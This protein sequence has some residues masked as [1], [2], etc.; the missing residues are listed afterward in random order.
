MSIRS[1]NLSQIDQISILKFQIR[2]S[3]VMI[4]FRHVLRKA[5]LSVI[6][7]SKSDFFKLNTTCGGVVLNLTG[8]E[9]TSC[10]SHHYH[11]AT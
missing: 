3:L 11:V 5:F 10:S 7:V 2:Y 9:Y 4:S 6:G 1:Q 8:H